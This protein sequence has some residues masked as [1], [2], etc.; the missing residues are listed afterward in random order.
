VNIFRQN[1]LGLP[2]MKHGHLVTLVN[3]LAGDVGSNESAAA[4]EQDPHDL[5]RE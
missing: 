3:E 1:G 4:D 5:L 2:A